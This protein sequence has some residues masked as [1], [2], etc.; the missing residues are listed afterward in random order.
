MNLGNLAVFYQVKN[1][2]REKSVA[3]AAEA[4]SILMPHTENIPSTQESFTRALN[5]LRNWNLSNEEIRRLIA[6][7]QSANRSS[8]K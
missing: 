1:P 5:V 6:E 2:Q 4:L 8:E 3:C 7:K